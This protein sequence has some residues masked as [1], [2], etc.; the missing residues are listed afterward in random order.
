V[1]LTPH[2]IVAYPQLTHLLDLA[3]D[4]V[5]K[6]PNNPDKLYDRGLYR[7]ADGQVQGA[8]DDLQKALQL[9]PAAEL[10]GKVKK[11]YYEAL[12]DLFQTDFNGASNRY[13]DD[14]R[15]LSKASDNPEE[16]Q[17][18]QARFYR[19]VGQGRESQGNLVE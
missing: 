14:F 8:V 2:E 9:K 15:E 10:A 16:E 11:Q 1:S 12:T 7:L 4:A 5:Q 3:N 19:I 13:L 17:T 6:D 18:R